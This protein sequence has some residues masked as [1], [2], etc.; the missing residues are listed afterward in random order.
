[1]NKQIRSRAGIAS[2]KYIW[3]QWRAGL[4][5]RTLKEGSFDAFEAIATATPTITTFTVTNQG[6]VTSGLTVA[7]TCAGAAA[8]S[9]AAATTA[10]PGAA[11][12]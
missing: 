1:L 8:Y 9:I 3:S 10:A 5:G 7:I 11:W 12:D 6:K 2:Q 4:R